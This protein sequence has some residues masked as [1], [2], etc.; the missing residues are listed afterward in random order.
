[1]IADPDRKPEDSHNSWMAQKIED[2]WVF[3][4]T[5]DAEKKTHPC[6]VPFGDLSVAQQAKDF[7]FI[8][9]VRQVK[10]AIDL[11]DTK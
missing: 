4:D 11:V 8:A 9:V 1:M 2:G 3:G 5:K 7:L 6:M 10:A